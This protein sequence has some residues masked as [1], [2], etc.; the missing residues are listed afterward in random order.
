[1]RLRQ[2]KGGEDFR[3]AEC[4]VPNEDAKKWRWMLREA[5]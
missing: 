4:Y 5:R 1:M 3:A 2:L